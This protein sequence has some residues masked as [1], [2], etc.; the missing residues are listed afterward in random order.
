MTTRPGNPL[1][2]WDFLVLRARGHRQRARSLMKETRDD[3]HKMEPR[4]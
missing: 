4:R 3:T 2:G 1:H